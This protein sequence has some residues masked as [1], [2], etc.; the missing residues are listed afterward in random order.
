MDIKKYDKIYNL[1]HEDNAEIFSNPETFVCIQEKM[2]GGN[3][4]VYIKNGK[5]IFGSRTQQLTSDEGEDTNVQ[6]NF[7]RALD[8]IREKLKDKDLSHLEGYTLFGE[9][10]IKHTINYN[11]DI[12]PPFLGFDVYDGKDYLDWYEAKGIFERLGFEFVPIIKVC[13]VKDIQ[14]P[15]TDE[16][17][18]TS[19]YT[20]G[21]AEGVV[22][23]TFNPRIYGKYVRSEFKERNKEVF[24][25]NKKHATN[26]EEYIV[27]LYCNNYRIEKQILKLM[28]DGMELHLSMMTKLP[29]NVYD[30][31][32]EENYKEISHLKQKTICFDVLRKQITK[33]CLTVLQNFIQNNILSETFIKDGKL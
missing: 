21:T 30:D 26:D 20:M 31:I 15:I 2:D 7:K 28:D 14:L 9:I 29:T 6:K 13:Q 22:F 11:W 27:S 16:F 17:V 19:K 33:R 5:I 23:K 18:P 8:F 24:G 25:M 12:T 10:M 4:R 1:G 3:G 32:W